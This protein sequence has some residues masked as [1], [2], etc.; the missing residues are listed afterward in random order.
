MMPMNEQ[1]ELGGII[2]MPSSVAAK[3]FTTKPSIAIRTFYDARTAQ[4][5]SIGHR[6]T[7]GSGRTDFRADKFA[8]VVTGAYRDCL[9]VLQADV[10]GNEAHASLILSGVIQEFYVIDILKPQRSI[11]P[12]SQE[13]RKTGVIGPNGAI[14]QTPLLLYLFLMDTKTKEVVWEGN[15]TGFMTGEEFHRL[16]YATSPFTL[17]LD[18]KGKLVKEV[19][20]KSIERSLVDFVAHDELL[21]IIAKYG[22]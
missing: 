11:S 13:V 16:R 9:R 1:V 5:K 18:A 19:V 12:G 4:F 21:A 20:A 3:R 10:T 2:A 17:N 14:G 8:E 22:K 15:T 7:G 6:G